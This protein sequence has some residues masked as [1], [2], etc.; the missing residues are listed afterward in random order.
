[1]S[2][3]DCMYDRKVNVLREHYHYF[4]FFK[5]RSTR[6]SW[7]RVCYDSNALLLD[8]KYFFWHMRSC[9]RELY[10]NLIRSE[11]GQNISFLMYLA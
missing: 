8:Y 2:I 9:P 3:I 6:V 5:E 7:F 4:Q 10:H 11:R 1:M